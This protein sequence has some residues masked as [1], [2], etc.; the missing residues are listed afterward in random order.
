MARTDQFQITLPSNSSLKFFGDNKP[1]NFTT[2]LPVRLSME[3]QWEVALMDIQYPISG[4]NVQKDLTI[5]VVPS[6]EGKK[7]KATDAFDRYVYWHMTG[8][9]ERYP[10]EPLL[11]DEP[12]KTIVNWDVRTGLEPFAYARFTVPHGYYRSIKDVITVLN[13]GFEAAYNQMGPSVGRPLRLRYDPD[14]DLVETENVEH[15]VSLYTDNPILNSIMGFRNVYKDVK[16]Y[17]IGIEKKFQSDISPQLEVLQSMYIYTDIIK[18]QLVGDL[19]SPLLGVLPVKGE[20][21]EQAF[22][23]F[24][25]PYYVPL[26]QSELD[27]I[28]IQ[29]RTDTGDPFPLHPNGKVIVRLHFRRKPIL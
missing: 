18:Y 4:Q 27:T 16:F 20:Y 13:K 15:A 7:R 14:A 8:D 5:G 21:K 23:Y 25:P 11:Q 22:W 2:K 28:N 24:S 6:I 9:R 29:L 3:G 26:N 10:Q 1:N 17:E 12:S 19:E